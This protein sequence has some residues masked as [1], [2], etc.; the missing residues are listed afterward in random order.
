VSNFINSK[1]RAKVSHY[2]TFKQADL[3]TEM[4]AMERD[5]KSWRTWKAHLVVWQKF[6][7]MK[8][9]VDKMEMDELA[10]LEE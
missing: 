2:A 9:D 1:T 4:D 7:G 5:L 10:A 8:Y 3:R 6:V